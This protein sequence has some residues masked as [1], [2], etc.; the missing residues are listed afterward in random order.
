M[1][2]LVPWLAVLLVCS[3]AA[4]PVDTAYDL[5]DAV[6]WQDG[7]ALES[8][9]SCDLYMAFTVFVDQMRALRDED[10]VLVESLLQSRYM[11]RI[12][13]ADFESLN[14]QEI[15]GVLLGEVVIQPDE[16]VM[17]ETAEM[18]GRNA[19]VVIYYFNGASISFQMVWENG[20]WRITDTSLLAFL[21]H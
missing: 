9:V 17:R 2:A 11:G 21:F 7:Y 13:V 5:L 19:T 8:I 1:K 10:P 20:D 15:L 6:E 18:E 12:T 14:N 16:Q 4:S 3:V